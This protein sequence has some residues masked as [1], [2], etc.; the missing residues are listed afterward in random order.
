MKN[1]LRV[2]VC[3][4]RDFTDRRALW[5]ILSKLNPA[6]IVHG[7]AMGAD[8]AAH[9]WAK[10]N[11]RKA[12][13]WFPDYNIAKPRHAPLIRNQRMIDSKPDIVVACPG[14]SGTLHCVVRARAAGLDVIEVKP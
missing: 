3:G 13:A 2:L 7:G 11:G 10:D 5:A 6:V 12:E 8:Q 9:A 1:P 4:G 14:G